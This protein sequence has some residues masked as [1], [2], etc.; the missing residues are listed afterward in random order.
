VK[1]APVVVA[2]LVSHDGARWLPQVIEG[3]RAQRVS[4]HRVLAVDTGSKDASRDLIAAAFGPGA[5]L[6]APG[7]TSFP[8]AVNRGVNAAA[9]AEWIWILHDDSTPDPGALAALLDYVDRDPRVDIVGPKLRD[10]PSL[11]R[12]QEI[13]VTMSGTGRRE[14]GLERGEYDQGQ[15]DQE[16]EVLAVHSAG[17]LIR[18]T[19]LSELR[20]FDEQLPIFGNDL[21]LGWRAA[22]A[23]F[24]TVAVPSAVVFHAEAAHR[25][26][27]RTSLTGR[28]T[29]YAERRAALFTLL[30]NVPS[31]ALPFQALRILVGSLVRVLGFLSIRAVGQALDELAAVVSLYAHPRA[32]QRARR[33]RRELVRGDPGRVRSLLPPWWV[34][35]RHGLDAIADLISAAT[36]QAQDVAERR[37]LARQGD[38]AGSW[39]H[40]GA[41][42]GG[43]PGS[44]DA[45][46][47]RRRRLIADDEDEELPELESGLLARF[48]TSPIALAV[49]GFLLL[50]GWA[51]RGALG[52]AFADGAGALGPAPARTSDW[53][54][55]HLEGWHPLAQGTAVPAPPYVLPFAVAGAVVPGGPRWVVAVV[56]MLA[57]PVGF[58][59]AWR[60]L[61]VAG[62]LLNERGMPRP[63]LLVGAAAYSLVC[64]SSG[65]WSAGRFGIVVSAALLPWLA[66][67]ALGFAEPSAARRWR[68]GWRSGMFLF[69]IVCFTPQIWLLALVICILIVGSALVLAPRSVRAGSAWGPP[70]LALAIPGVVL[71]PWWV[72]LLAMGAGEGLLLEAGRLPF[73]LVSGFDLAAGRVSSSGSPHW[74]GLIAPALALVALIPAATRLPVLICWIVGS[75]GAVV[76]LLLGHLTLTLPALTTAPSLGVLAVFFQGVSVVAVMLAAQGLLQ[77]GGPGH[78]LVRFGRALGALCALVPIVGV[79][80]AVAY[81]GDRVAAGEVPD[82]PAYMTQ[83]STLSP[84]HGVLIVRGTV[85]QGLRYVVRRGD[86][87]TIGEDEILALTPVD[88]DLTEAVVGLTSQP[89]DELIEG[90]AAEGIE[91]V[92]LTAPADGQVASRLDAVGGL[93]PVSTENRDTRA[94]QVDRTPTADAIAGSGPGY[95]YGLVGLQLL[96]IVVGLIMCGPGRR[97]RYDSRTGVADG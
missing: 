10:W 62:R 20:G 61:R 52:G 16:R 23:G 2:L 46:T 87:L 21:D 18:R 70:A 59:G 53:W 44:V 60:F 67:A 39:A 71:A 1:S 41:R 96:A 25:G 89:T 45:P 91:F 24:R 66:H 51:L 92:V 93:T 6:S 79:L 90:L 9:D 65:A 33:G 30:A 40:S 55:L 31:R 72:P 73:D 48:L 75:S 54:Q 69:L 5:V 37:R 14:T 13:G 95:R 22:Q 58:W 74:L 50:S 88:A 68:A 28:H 43:D 15:H 97:P 81:A 85:T 42:A 56:L 32:L 35:Y 38:P 83:S 64:V 12:L 34:P 29:H 8:A 17:M 4:P 3:L 78:R 63:L 19:V 27:R 47:D 86:G 36:Q 57:V 26:V 84:A 94:W 49:T 7:S 77:S 11:R 76:A 80:W 82:I